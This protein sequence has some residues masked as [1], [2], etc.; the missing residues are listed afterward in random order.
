MLDP[1]RCE[2][3]EQTVANSASDNYA[4]RLELLL[5][6]SSSSSWDIG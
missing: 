5:P 3:S 4:S 1:I 6:L 2:G